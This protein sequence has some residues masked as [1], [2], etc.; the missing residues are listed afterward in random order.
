LTFA[1]CSWS[2]QL[3][4]AMIPVGYFLGEPFFDCGLGSGDQ[5]QATA[6]DLGKV[7]GYHMGDS[8]ALRLLLELS[9]DPAAL[10]P[11]Q[12]LLKLRFGIL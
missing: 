5:V 1:A 6:T 10:G 11:V 2:F 12:N 9:A 4:G 7:F 8:V 3:L